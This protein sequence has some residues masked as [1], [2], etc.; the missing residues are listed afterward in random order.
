MSEN[1]AAELNA[2]TFDLG[3]WL[4]GTIT[5]TKYTC[6][7]RLN[8]DAFRRVV[9]LQERGR[10][11]HAALTQATEAAEK[12]TGSGSLGEVSPAAEKVEE[13]RKEFEALKEEHDKARA[14]LEASELTIVLAADDRSATR[15]VLPILQEHFPEVLK[16]EE[17]TQAK[18]MSLLRTNPEIMDKQNAVILHSTIESVTTAQGQTVQRNEITLEWVEMILGGISQPDRERL[19]QNMNLA[20]NSSTLTEEAIDAGF[21]G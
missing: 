19:F 4:S 6:K 14:E 16:G 5:S 2:G 8:L 17:M 12:S 21:P 11:V 13:L 10:D 9:E 18:M 15:G 7:V 3:Q 20:I 1:K